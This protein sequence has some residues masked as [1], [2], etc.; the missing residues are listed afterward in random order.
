MQS[1]AQLL[2]HLQVPMSR[3]EPDDDLRKR[4]AAME[5]R[6]GVSRIC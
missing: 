5:D 4:Y 3:M 6:L 2:T 1:G